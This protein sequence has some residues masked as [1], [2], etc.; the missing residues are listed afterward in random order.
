MDIPRWWAPILVVFA[1]YQQVRF[2]F[3]HHLPLEVVKSC[4]SMVVR[5]M[6]VDRLLIFVILLWRSGTV[7]S[8]KHESHLSAERCPCKE[9]RFFRFAN[10]RFMPAFV[11]LIT[12][13]A[14]VLPFPNPC[15]VPLS[16]A[17]KPPNGCLFFRSEEVFSPSSQWR[18]QYPNFVLPSYPW[19]TPSESFLRGYML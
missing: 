17:P 13:N 10:F 1:E 7:W 5:F 3:L 18:W 12:Q 19:V 6:D 16:P 11:T 4:T 9:R 2:P 14:S 8:R 15:F